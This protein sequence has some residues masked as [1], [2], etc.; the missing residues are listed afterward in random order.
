MARLLA[1]NRDARLPNA[2]TALQQLQSLLDSGVL[3]A[4]PLVPAGAPAPAPPPPPVAHDE[5]DEEYYE[6]EEPIAAAAAAAAAA[7]GGAAAGQGHIVRIGANDSTTVLPGAPPYRYDQR[8]QTPWILWAGLGLVVLVIILIVVAL[9]GGGGGTSTVAVP[10]VVNKTQD[11]A[12]AALRRAGLKANA[13][14]I[15]NDTVANG[16]VYAS[17]P[18]AGK[19]VAKGS[20]V[21]LSVSSGPVETST[22]EPPTTVAPPTTARRT[23]TTRRQVTTTRPRVTTTLPRTSTTPKTTVT[24]AG[25]TTTT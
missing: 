21:S 15:P 1:K 25:T 24:T 6:T 12:V 14:S 2:E 11:D 9:S 20:T 18:Q 3:G 16:I 4:E 17:D 22:T 23:T 13:V 7:A 19:K 10:V 5:Y 8:R